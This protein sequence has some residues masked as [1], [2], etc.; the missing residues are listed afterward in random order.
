M[1]YVSEIR[2]FHHSNSN[3]ILQ[4]NYMATIK[5]SGL[6]DMSKDKHFPLK[7]HYIILNINVFPVGQ[8]DLF[9]CST[10]EMTEKKQQQQISRKYLHTHTLN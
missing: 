9:R 4:L 8:I 7:P 6:S 3:L 1:R 2:Q 5:V 10:N